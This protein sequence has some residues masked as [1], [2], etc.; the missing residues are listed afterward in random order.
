[1]ARLNP[2]KV[3]FGSGLLLLGIYLVFS[4]LQN[5]SVVFIGLVAMAVGIGLLAS[6]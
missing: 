5:M 4:N 6:K 2:W 3:G 1:M